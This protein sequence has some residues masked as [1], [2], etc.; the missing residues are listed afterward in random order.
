MAGVEVL[1][2]LKFSPG[3]FPLFTHTPF[4]VIFGWSLF[5][6]CLLSFSFG[7][8]YIFKLHL[9]KNGVSSGERM[10]VRDE[11]SDSDR[12][13]HNSIQDNNYDINTNNKHQKPTKTYKKL[14]SSSE[15][16]D[17]AIDASLN[18]RRRSRTIRKPRRYLS[19]D[20]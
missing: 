6:L 9:K 3:Q 14:S 20:E 10:S 4:I 16:S 5:L 1:V 13:D 15:D 11:V 8:F 2:W 18:S 7:Y 12:V 19:D 17:S